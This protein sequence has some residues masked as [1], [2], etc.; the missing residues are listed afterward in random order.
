[1][2]RFYYCRVLVRTTLQQSLSHLPP[3][4]L[5]SALNT[6]MTVMKPGVELSID[7][8]K[9]IAWSSRKLQEIIQHDY[10]LDSVVELS[11]EIDNSVAYLCHDLESREQHQPLQITVTLF[12]EA[13]RASSE[14]IQASMTSSGWSVDVQPIQELAAHAST[15]SIIPVLDEPFS[16]VLT[17]IS[18]K[19]WDTLKQVMGR[20][21]HYS[22]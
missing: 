22:G 18:T 15:K 12:K 5:E 21:G 9:Q 3:T 19:Q 7:Y 1:M 8:G 2:S 6:P 14:V 4:M 17:G 20:V 13:T 11:D 10:L 16:P